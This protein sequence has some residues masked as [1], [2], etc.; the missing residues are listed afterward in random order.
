MES[1]PTTF[2]SQ[3]SKRLLKWKPINPDEPVTKAVL[4][5]AIS[6]IIYKRKVLFEDF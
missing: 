6:P 5:I 1:K 4:L 2:Q 3:E